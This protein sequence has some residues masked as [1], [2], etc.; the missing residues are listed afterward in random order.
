ML[1]SK[2]SRF[3]NAYKACGDANKSAI[4]AGYAI[5][6][7]NVEANRL[8]K[9]AKVVQELDQWRRDKQK[10]FKR[11]DFVDIALGKFNSDIREEI[12]PRYLELAGRGAGH[13]GADKS[14]SNT[15]TNNIQLNLTHNNINGLSSGEALD[16][17]R[18]L[19]A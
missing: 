11:D 16:L 5:K 1:T 8:L 17:I 13:I 12:K 7:A 4:T 15:T 6:S 9:N 10:E 3:V 14:E 18:N 2:Q 19:L